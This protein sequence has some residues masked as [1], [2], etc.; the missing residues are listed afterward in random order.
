VPKFV[1]KGTQAAIVQKEKRRRVEG[2]IVKHSKPSS[3]KFT[4][5]K[6]KAII[7]TVD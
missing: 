3:T 7:R 6:A 4:D 1:K 2:N 5:D